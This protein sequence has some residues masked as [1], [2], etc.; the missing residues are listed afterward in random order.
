M[1]NVTCQEQADP[2]HKQT[3]RQQADV[4]LED[5]FTELFVWVQCLSCLFLFCSWFKNF[6]FINI[7]FLP[8][9]LSWCAVSER[10]I[11][12]WLQTSL[13]GVRKECTVLYVMFTMHHLFCC[14]F[15]VTYI[16]N[17]IWAVY[18][19][20]KLINT[21][22]YKNWTLCSF[23]S[24]N[25]NFFFFL[26]AIC[27]CCVRTPSGVEQSYFA[28]RYILSNIRYYVVAMLLPC[29]LATLYQWDKCF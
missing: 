17:S 9:S 11:S 25:V 2:R 22:S 29:C 27:S 28:H 23:P 15:Y 3:H 10:S 13:P 18:T 6:S 8:L 7:F 1:N 19:S 16:L 26:R 14:L 4:T 24:V 5:R 20:S 21:I 12:C